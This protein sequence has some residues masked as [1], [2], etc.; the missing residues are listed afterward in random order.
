MLPKELVDLMRNLGVFPTVLATSDKE[1][2]I[3]MTFI[4]WVYPVDERTI[5]IALSSNAKS[6]K[7]MLQTGQA[8]LM[9]IAQDKA[10]TC[11]GNANLLID[12]I[13]EVKFPVS[14]FEVKI[15]SVENNLFPGGTIT[16]TIPFMHTGDLQ[17]AGELDQ[18]VLD[19]LRSA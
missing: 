12:R 19:A 14:V 10:L 13:E 16:G 15:Q 5:K 3:H 17:K 11:Y 6:A 9:L 7:N 18:L 2:N 8:C 1:S 4:T